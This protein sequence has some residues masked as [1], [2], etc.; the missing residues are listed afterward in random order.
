[1]LDFIARPMGVMVKFIYD[2]LKFIDNPVISAYAMAIIVAGVLLKL[3][4][5]PLTKK[6][7]DSMKDMQKLQ[8][9]LEKLKKK[10]KNDKDTLNRKTMKLYQEHNINP[11]GGCLPLLIQF[12]ILIGFFY[13]LR[14]P[15]KYAF[16]SQAVYDAMNKS[17][18]WIKDL[19]FAANHVFED[20]LVNGLNI[21][22]ALPFIGQALPILALIAGLTTYYQSKMMQSGQSGGNDQAAST[23]NTMTKIM[24]LMIFFFALNFPAGLTLYWTV[25]NTF[26][27]V[28][29]YIA[30]NKGMKIREAK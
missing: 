19:G 8:P 4:L 26:Q 11:M 20:G 18:L 12:P 30:L 15:V 6:Q 2:I 29:Q 27:I 7:T 13:V 28:Q 5:L 3:V 16:K 23:Q 14:D 24:P 21:G 25:S 10:Y 9:E 22:V 17:F 1:M